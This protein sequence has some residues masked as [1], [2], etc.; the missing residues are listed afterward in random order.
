MYRITYL[1]CSAPRSARRPQVKALT[2][3]VE[4]DAEHLKSLQDDAS[5]HDEVI[6]SLSTDID[7]LTQSER[8]LEEEY[9]KIKTQGIGLT[10]TLTPEQ[11][12]E[13]EQIREAA[14]GSWPRKEGKA[15]YL[16]D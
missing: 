5:N 16:I 1:A 9:Q 6:A 11:E 3:Q 10:E 13:Y 4:T 2:K 12:A 14:G 8:K 15:T 7:S